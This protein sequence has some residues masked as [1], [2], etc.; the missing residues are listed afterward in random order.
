MILTPPENA[1][2]DNQQHANRD[3]NLHILCMVRPFPLCANYPAFERFQALPARVVPKQTSLTAPSNAE[4]NDS[5]QFPQAF[6]ES[7]PTNQNRA[8]IKTDE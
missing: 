5:Q 7:F 3:P 4:C 1:D 6:R 8:A 2:E